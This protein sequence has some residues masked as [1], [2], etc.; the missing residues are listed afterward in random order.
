MGMEIKKEV[1]STQTSLIL[2]PF[3]TLAQKFGSRQRSEEDVTQVQC[4]AVEKPV[5]RSSLLELKAKAEM[6]KMVI[7]DLL[8]GNRE[9]LDSEDKHSWEMKERIQGEKRLFVCSSFP[10]EKI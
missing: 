1:V 10:V 9:F 8:Q 6:E 4:F 2:M 3:P 7:K 5:R